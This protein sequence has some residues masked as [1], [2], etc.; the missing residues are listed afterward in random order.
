MSATISTITKA[1][2]PQREA[3]PSRAELDAA[4]KGAWKSACAVTAATDA[5]SRGRDHLADCEVAKVAA[6]E[7]IGVAREIDARA[8]VKQLRA[9]SRVND[10]TAIQRA[11]GE[12]T[13]AQ[14][15]I[16]V[17]EVAV[18]QLRAD[19]ASAEHEHLWRQN[20]IIS[21]RNRILVPF[22]ERLLNRGR[23]A[24][25]ELAICEV[26]L[27][28]LLQHDAGAPQFPGGSLD[29][30]RAKDMREEPLKALYA[31]VERFFHGH[32]RDDDQAAA[33]SAVAALSA[34]IARLTTDP[35]VSIE[36]PEL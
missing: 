3:D 8:A 31:E 25:R 24:R 18:E 35:T 16:T 1:T 22:V 26:L 14:D 27:P 20:A 2:E 5:L 13:D 28:A 17:A 4:I 6:E 30:I 11:R 34:A 12:L 21:A 10:I 23:A 15:A 7:A 36:L 9:N 33:R 19:L 32:G 29:S